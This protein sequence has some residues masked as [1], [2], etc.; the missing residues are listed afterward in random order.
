MD[1]KI[2]R[3]RKLIE[4]SKH[5]VI[6]TGA[7]MSTN[8][9]IKD[10]RSK[11]GL[12]NDK[13][14]QKKYGFSYEEIVSHS[15]FMKNPKLFYEYYFNEMVSKNAKPSEGYRL[16]NLLNKKCTIITQN[17]DGLHKISGN[18]KVLEIHGTTN[19][20]HCMNC[21][22]KYYFSEIR[23]MIHDGIPKC[24]CG[25]II[26]PDVVLF[27]EGLDENILTESIKAIEEADLL[28]VIGSSL[29]VNP[30]ASLPYYFRGLN[31]VII[32]KDPTPLDYKSGLVIRN[33]VDEVLKKV[34]SK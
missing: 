23:T 31:F 6:L 13:T 25:G 30:A 19:E 5:I 34:L 10:I 4:I 9:G 18:E 22:S 29:L 16:L 27:E 28:I 17:I 15:F 7:G 33:D 14:K 11:D 21:G 8:S 1:E 3:L 32:N 24:D 26:K 20:Y 2:I 12:A